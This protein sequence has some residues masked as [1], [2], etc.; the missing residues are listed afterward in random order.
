MTLRNLWTS[1]CP[2]CRR[3]RWR[4]TF[5]AV[6]FWTLAGMTLCILLMGCHFSLFGA[7]DLGGGGDRLPKSAPGA[8]GDD[9]KGVPDSPA[10]PFWADETL[11][12]ALGGAIATIGGAWWV[13]QNSYLAQKPKWETVKR[14]AK[15]LE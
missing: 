2:L 12:T 14:L 11:L 6:A 9:G 8:M 4:Y 5:W 3:D 13:R 15:P 7:P 1:Q 10:P